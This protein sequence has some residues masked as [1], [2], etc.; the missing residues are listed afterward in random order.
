VEKQKKENDL[1]KNKL[2]TYL[3]HLIFKG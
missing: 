1:T 3:N 2:K